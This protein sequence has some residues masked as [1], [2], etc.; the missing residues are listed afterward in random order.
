VG[1]LFEMFTEGTLVGSTIPLSGLTR[2][3]RI[4]DR[5]VFPWL[6]LAIRDILV[7][8]RDRFYAYVVHNTREIQ[9]Y[10]H[11]AEWVT[12][13][14]MIK[15]DYNPRGDNLYRK[16]SLMNLDLC[17]FIVFITLVIILSLRFLTLIKI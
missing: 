16:L 7:S 2:F 5:N 11:Q 13:F 12:F 8:L 4:V 9:E 14:T 10:A 1:S 3:A 17:I 15:V 6:G